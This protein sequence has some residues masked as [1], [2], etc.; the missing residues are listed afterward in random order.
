[1]LSEYLNKMDYL[2]HSEEY[3]KMIWNDK[4]DENL[5]KHDEYWNGVEQGIE[6]GI[7]KGIQEGIQE[8]IQQGIEQGIQEGIEQNR[9]QMI[10][11][12]NNN[13]VPLD[14]ISKS[15]KLSI[16]EVKKIIEENKS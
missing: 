13:G 3:C 1:M 2:S 8:G 14:I 15:S 12:L 5:R 16:D 9:I 11:D 7:Q 4:L 6:Q 10:I